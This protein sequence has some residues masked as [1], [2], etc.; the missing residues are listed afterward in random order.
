MTNEQI[1][2][3]EAAIRHFDHTDYSQFSD[4]EI[5]IAK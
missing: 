5:K 4:D 3:R 1:T 2:E